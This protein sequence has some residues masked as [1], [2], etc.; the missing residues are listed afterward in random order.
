MSYNNAAGALGMPSG[1][2]YFIRFS[3]LGG[4]WWTVQMRLLNTNGV[5]EG[6]EMMM[7]WVIDPM[8]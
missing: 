7:H 2:Y 8:G 5:G 6:R 3:D 4:E 1:C